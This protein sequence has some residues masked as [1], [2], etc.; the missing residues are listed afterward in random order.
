MKRFWDCLRVAG[1]KSSAI[2]LCSGSLGAIY[3]IS[4][5]FAP[6]EAPGRV[7]AGLL[8]LVVLAVC[9]LPS[10]HYVCSESADLWNQWKG[11]HGRAEDARIRRAESGEVSPVKI[12][13]RLRVGWFAGQKND[14]TYKTTLT[15]CSC[16]DFKKRGVPCKHM[17]YLAMECGILGREPKDV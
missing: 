1:F 14:E 6:S 4:A 8:L 17:Y 2:G 12:D 10:Y 13:P 3:L 9:L 5:P 11:V 7:G 15:R 16:P